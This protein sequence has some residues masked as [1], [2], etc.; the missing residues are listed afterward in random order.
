VK[1]TKS[2]YE[3]KINSF[4]KFLAQFSSTLDGQK[5]ESAIKLQT[6]IKNGKDFK[7]Q[8]LSAPEINVKTV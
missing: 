6:E 7:E 2:T 8:N 4:N 5:F 1:A 3:K